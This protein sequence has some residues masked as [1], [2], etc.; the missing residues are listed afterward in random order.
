LRPADADLGDAQSGL[1][2]Y[3]ILHGRLLITI[4]VTIVAV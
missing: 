2:Q 4:A 1:A 3:T